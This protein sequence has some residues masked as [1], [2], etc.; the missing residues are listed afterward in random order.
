MGLHALHVHAAASHRLACWDLFYR[1]HTKGVHKTLYAATLGPTH[2][3][4][5]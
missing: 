5:L 2:V 4:L 1:S 3:Q